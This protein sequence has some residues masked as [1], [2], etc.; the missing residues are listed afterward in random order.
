[1]LNT[2]FHID[3]NKKWKTVISNIHNLTEWM[4]I[5]HESGTIELLINGDAVEM[6]KKGTSV[7]FKKLI[8]LD[9][10]VTVCKNSLDQRNILISDVQEQVELVTS[11]VVELA[12]QQRS[13]FSYIKP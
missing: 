2:I 5:S 4:I 11:G 9:V 6:T 10:K 1:M 12:L 8:D 3:E 7:I 13:G